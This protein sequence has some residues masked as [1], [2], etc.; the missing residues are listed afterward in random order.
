VNRRSVLRRRQ[1]RVRG[2]ADD[3]VGDDNLLTMLIFGRLRA[4]F[5]EMRRQ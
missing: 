5:L 2:D 3:V 4:I 1:R